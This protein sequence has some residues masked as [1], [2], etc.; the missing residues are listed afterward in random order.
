[1]RREVEAQPQGAYWQFFVTDSQDGNCPAGCAVVDALIVS[2]GV[3]VPVALDDTAFPEEAVPPSLRL[4][5][6]CDAC[7][8]DEHVATVE[9]RRLCLGCLHGDDVPTT[10][11]PSHLADLFRQ[12]QGLG[13]ARL[14]LAR[15]RDGQPV[16]LAQTRD[17]GR[18][19]P[20]AIELWPDSNGGDLHDFVMGNFQRKGG[21]ER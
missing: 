8:D 16:A 5:S 7:Q 1:M 13:E 19:S 2:G 17:H 6:P 15:N 21:D 18:W 12:V 9:G 3:P 11:V 4:I 10:P 14:I 20:A